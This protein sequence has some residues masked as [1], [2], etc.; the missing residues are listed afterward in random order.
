M[1]G[2]DG[3]FSAADL[4][5]I[6]AVTDFN[7][8]ASGIG[9]GLIVPVVWGCEDGDSAELLVKRSLHTDTKDFAKR[10]ALHP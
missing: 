5:V 7:P 3:A 10:L 1:T 2:S 8:N 6:G 9:S 4:V